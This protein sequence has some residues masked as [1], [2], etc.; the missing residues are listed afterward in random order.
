VNTCPQL[1]VHVVIAYRHN[2]PLHSVAWEDVLGWGWKQAAK[3]AIINYSVAQSAEKKNLDQYFNCEEPALVG[4]QYV[5]L[6]HAH[7][8]SRWLWGLLLCVHC[9]WQGQCAKGTANWRITFA[10]QKNA[11]VNLAPSFLA[12]SH[13]VSAVSSS[14][15]YSSS[16]CHS[17]CARVSMRGF[18][19]CRNFT[20]ALAANAPI[21]LT[22]LSHSMR[23]QC[24]LL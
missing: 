8:S 22:P 2:A 17:V 16:A 4:T 9:P 11:S 18:I 13:W 15:W 3:W 23:F 5:H 20:G 12:P 10:G 14:L 1:A 24:T 6:Q 7:Y 19:S 21:V